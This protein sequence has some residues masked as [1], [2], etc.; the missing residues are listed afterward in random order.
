MGHSDA[1]K[2]DK[3][4]IRKFWEIQSKSNSNRWT[5][6]QL[7]QYDIE[8]VK[9]L[10]H[11]PKSILDLGCGSGELSKSLIPVD[12]NLTAV[13]F[14]KGFARFFAGPNMEFFCSDV[15][16]FEIK[17]EF[18]LILAFG[19]V[20]HLDTQSEKRLYAN[21]S[22]LL[23]PGGVALVKNQ[24]SLGNEDFVFN[25]YSEKLKM[26]YSARYPSLATQAGIL[27][28]MFRNVSIHKYPQEHQHQKDTQHVLFSCTK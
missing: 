28:A 16:S 24:V 9:S 27:E 18:D 6:S 25:G 12:G 20:T 15:A 1:G 11:S 4:L 10:S 2:L 8:I 26:I 17:K 13:D 7:L 3:E 23:G 22:K 14:E 19:L 5:G 21:I